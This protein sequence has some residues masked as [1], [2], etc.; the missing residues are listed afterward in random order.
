MNRSIHHNDNHSETVAHQQNPATENKCKRLGNYWFTA[1][2]RLIYVFLFAYTGYSKLNDMDSFIGGIGRI[3]FLGHHAELI[4]W[5]IPVLELILA[6]GMIL[7]FRKVLRGSL[8][9]SV[10]LMG[11]FTVYLL[12]MIVLVKER[13]CHCGGVIESLGWTQHLLL[14]SVLFIL[15]LWA[16][17]KNN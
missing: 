5:G 10:S 16:I 9:A 15:G 2:I 11:I 7:P 6:V 12:L 3:P 4:G 8:I 1:L 13:L 17:R 14:N